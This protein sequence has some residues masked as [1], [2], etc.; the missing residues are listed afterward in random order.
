MRFVD[1]FFFSKIPLFFCRSTSCSD[2]DTERGH[3]SR[4]QFARYS[5]GSNGRA[6]KEPAT[7]HH[8]REIIGKE[9]SA[10]RLEVR[11][12]FITTC[13]RKSGPNSPAAVRPAETQLALNG[14]REKACGSL[15]SSHPQILL[16]DDSGRY[17]YLR[18]ILPPRP[19]K[20]DLASS[21][22]S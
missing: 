14:E 13:E 1:Q 20:R 17:L 19:L 21:P 2:E 15:I 6:S 11:L 16:S 3:C 5:C 12:Q 9:S 8:S 18:R 4:L 10:H 7:L 22:R